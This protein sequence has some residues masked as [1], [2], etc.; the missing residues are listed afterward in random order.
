MRDR[1][2]VQPMRPFQVPGP[3]VRGLI[4]KRRIGMNES[5]REDRLNSEH[6]EQGPP[7]RDVALKRPGLAMCTD[8]RSCGCCIQHGRVGSR[9]GLVRRR[10]MLHRRHL[11]A[12]RGMRRGASAP[13]RSPPAVL[14]ASLAVAI[15]PRTGIPHTR[16]YCPITLNEGRLLN[17]LSACGYRAIRLRIV[18]HRPGA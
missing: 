2:A 18:R 15:S 4:L 10:S 13:P 1:R 7:A 8:S 16:R 3:Q 17:L 12:V 6:Y 11:P 5:D 9:R 14:M